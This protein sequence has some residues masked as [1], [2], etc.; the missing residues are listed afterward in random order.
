MPSPTKH[1]QTGVYYL[2]QR[3]PADLA[4]SPPSGEI[5]FKIGGQHISI[6]VRPTIK[7]SLRTKD[8]EEAKARY[9]VAD[10][11]LQA[12][13]QSRRR[14][15]RPL[16]WKEIQA[17]AGQAYK[18]W[19]NMVDEEPGEEAIWTEVLALDQSAIEKGKLE[20]WYGRSV[21]QLLAREGINTDRESW[22]RLLDAVAEALALAAKT[23]LRKA[24]GDYSPDTVV[25]RFPAW[26]SQ[27]TTPAP[28]PTAITTPATGDFDLLALLDHK[29][30]TQS[31]KAKT[32]RDYAR[33]IR[34]FIAFSG[35]SDATQITKHDV[36]GWRDKLIEDGSSPKTINGKA[37]AALSAVLSHAVKEFSLPD[38]V[39]KGIRDERKSGIVG[40]KGYTLDEA[41][42]IL[43]ATFEGSSKAL[44]APHARALFWVPWICAYTGLR[45]TEV[46]QL[47]GVDVHEEDGHP[48]FVVRPE[49]GSTKS[50]KAWTTAI[51]PH[52]LELGV[53]EM[54]RAVGDGPAFY[55]P[56]PTDV[57]LSQL[58]GGHRAQEVGKRVGKWITKELGIPAPGGR[59]NHAWRH[60]FTTLT[61][62]HHL[63]KQA[64]D[65]MLGSGSADAREG[66]GDWPATALAHEISKIPPVEVEDTGWRPSNEAVPALEER[67]TS[68]CIIRRGDKKKRARA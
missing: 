45:V 26:D 54:F 62:Q 8:P 39:A 15:Q 29:S 14:K 49:G 5:T 58:E 24:K 34:S 50:G 4:A 38:N 48:Y 27:G 10:A 2:R 19:V 57:D 47:Q 18:E 43:A 42:A 35:K 16:L 11:Q 64:R 67:T 28:T 52:L 13:W 31:Q 30:A 7:V 61:R 17:L 22:T 36:R 41:R 3:M 53:V 25:Q 23:N 66:Y 9:R 20:Q 6:A 44:S 40:R 65:W 33:E 46:A 60:R 32:T 63:D 55:T 68:L 21:D 37:L 56:Y 1:K 12:F 59:P 51:H